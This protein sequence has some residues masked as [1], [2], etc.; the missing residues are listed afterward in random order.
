M[1]IKYFE[2]Y[3]MKYLSMLK[4]GFL[5]L[6]S[7]IGASWTVIK[8]I[9]FF[10]GNTINWHKSNYTFI[11]SVAIS[12]GYSIYANFP[13]RKIRKKIAGTEAY[14]TIKYGDIL[15]SKEHI[16]V[17]SS[18]LF[19]T[20]LSII[21]EKSLLGQIIN[22]FF[23][24]DNSKIEKDIKN[25]LS[26]ITY[27]K[28]DVSKGKNLS[29]PIGT[30]ATFD[31]NKNQKVFLMAITKIY[32]ENGV[33]NIESNISYIHKAINELWD[34]TDKDADNGILNIV[35][36]GAGISKAFNRTVES[37]L[38]IIQS[39]IDRAKK[40]RPCSELVIYLRRKDICLAE[41]MELKK[42]TKFLA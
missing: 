26:K 29:Y 37:V 32:E 22:K 40:K 6:F 30:I 11:I 28:I 39:F 27:E 42:I 12:L 21:S 15:E 31:I 35:P 10:W 33:E 41:Y 19:N 7:L 18:N 36:L 38:Y 2:R 24:G 1:K 34:K 14:L 4:D 3:K 9:D 20:S 17:S 8:F 25:S 16:A 5:T 23:E 13:F